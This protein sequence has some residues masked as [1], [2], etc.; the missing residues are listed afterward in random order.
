M[1]LVLLLILWGELALAGAS[2]TLVTQK[3][4][5]GCELDPKRRGREILIW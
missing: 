5:R 1:A 3:L 2:G 4:P